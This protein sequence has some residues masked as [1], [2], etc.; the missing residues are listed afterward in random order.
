MADD[1]KI[2]PRG[3]IAFGNGDLVQV[4]NVKVETTNNARLKHTLRK[5]GAGVTLGVEETTISFDMEINE[6]GPE[7]NYL[8]SIKTGEIK[9]LRVKIPEET[10]TCNGVFTKRSLELPLDDAIKATID[11]IGTLVE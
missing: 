7:K 4:T 6:D 1:F 11:F 3:S 5:K 2:Y 9:Q 8:K 10:I